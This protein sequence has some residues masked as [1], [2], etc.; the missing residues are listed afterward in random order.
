V[1][2]ETSALYLN[3]FDF[4]DEDL[5]ANG[6]GRLTPGQREWLWMTG[7]GI[8]RS[9]KAMTRFAIVFL[10]L[11]I[12]FIAV[13][14]M[15]NASTRRAFSSSSVNLVVIAVGIALIVLLLSLSRIIAAR[16][17]RRLANAQIRT[18]EGAVRLEEDYS[19]GAS[20]TVYYARVG[21]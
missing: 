20:I 8:R 9:S 13:L 3:L 1:S 17:A 16:T 4:T 15:Q 14:F 11:A 2:T 12:G 18:A 21:K 7:Q 10:L 19:P 6:A 5:L